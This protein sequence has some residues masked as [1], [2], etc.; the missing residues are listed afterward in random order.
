MNKLHAILSLLREAFNPSRS[1]IVPQTAP[2]HLKRDLV[3]LFARGNLL[4]QMG[5]YITAEDLE[6]R[7][8]A[9]HGYRFSPRE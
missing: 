5:C 7:K 8:A 6:R 1:E 4:L 2:R 3:T 9:L